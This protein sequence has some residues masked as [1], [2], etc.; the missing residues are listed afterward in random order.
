MNKT[1]QA[2][3]DVYPASAMQAGM[4]FHSVSTAGSELYFEQCRCLLE[5]IQPEVLRRAWEQVIQSH[6]VLRTSFAWQEHRALQIVWRKVELG[7]EEQDWQAY[8]AATREQR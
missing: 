2:I 6:P 1:T 5:G 8:D 7:W 4:L 3:E